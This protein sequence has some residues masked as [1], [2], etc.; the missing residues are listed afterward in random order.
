MKYD[1]IAFSDVHLGIHVKKEQ[2]YCKWGAF[3]KIMHLWKEDI[4]DAAAFCEFVK[5]LSEEPPKNLV[6]LGDLL[7]FWRK[8]NHEV[9]CRNHKVLKALFSLNCKIYYVVG[10]HDY[11]IYELAQKYKKNFQKGG[12]IEFC[13]DIRLMSGREY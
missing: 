6:I 11:L 1:I 3:L 5:A 10:N 8:T 2:E 7:E 13:K 4:T 12:D 9:L